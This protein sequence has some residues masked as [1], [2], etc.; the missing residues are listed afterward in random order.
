MLNGS[1]K[2]GAGAH[3]YDRH[4][5]GPPPEAVDWLLPAGCARALD[6]GA[7]TGHL[8]RSLLERVEDVVAVDPDPRMLAV[9]RENCA[10]SAVLEG[11]AEDIPLPDNRVDAVFAS[12]A[13][14]WVDQERALPEVARVLEPGGALGLVW[15]GW[16]RSAPWVEELEHDIREHP[17]GQDAV[18][19]AIR[20]T[21]ELGPVQEGASFALED[22]QVITTR[23][24]LT[25]D[26]V[27]MLYTT[28][29]WYLR[30]P[31]HRRRALWEAITARVAALDEVVDMPLASHCWRLRHRV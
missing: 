5:P 23:Y 15:T 9:L 28:Y 6:L 2:F 20:R 16:D 18:H 8:T 30:E 17:G 27:A 26:E 12:C 19:E 4:R 29:S 1:R 7:G 22:S 10:P 14:H 11:T 25:R 3:N 21:H 13:W 31:E 24:R